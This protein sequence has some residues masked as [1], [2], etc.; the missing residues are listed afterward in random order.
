MVKHSLQD[1]F[2]YARGAFTPSSVL[3]GP[4]LHVL[5]I[6][7][8]RR[9]VV[10]SVAA[11][12]LNLS[13]LILGTFFTRQRRG[14]LRETPGKEQTSLFPYPA[15]AWLSPRFLQWFWALLLTMLWAHCHFSSTH[16][17][18]SLGAVWKSGVLDSRCA[19]P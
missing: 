2:S 4:W 13:S 16:F 8:K 9:G 7:L 1:C 18:P 15:Q 3:C 12:L 6:Y 17:P 19:R 5:L 14:F 11:L 10:S